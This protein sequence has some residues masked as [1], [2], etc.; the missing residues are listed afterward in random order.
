M[1]MMAKKAFR[2]D[3]QPETG[4]GPTDEPIVNAFYNGA[5]YQF[6]YP[7]PTMN[8]MDLF[9]YTAPIGIVA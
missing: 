5:H 2:L 4:K 8:Q 3:I 6:L 1:M 7:C 9:A